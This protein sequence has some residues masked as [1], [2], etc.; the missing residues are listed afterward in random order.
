MT[1]PTGN[2]I[3]VD[4]NYDSSEWKPISLTLVE[5]PKG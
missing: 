1:I 3:H 2:N 5:Y 4:I